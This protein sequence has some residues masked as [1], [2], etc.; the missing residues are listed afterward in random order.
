MLKSGQGKD[1]LH[2]FLKSVTIVSGLFSL[3]VCIIILLNYLQLRSANPLNSL[4][5]EELVR[6]YRE[7]PGDDTLKKEIR[8]FDLLI[9]KAF[10][11]QRWHIQTGGYL[12]IA[13]FSLFFVSFSV[14][15]MLKKKPPRPAGNPVPEKIRKSRFLSRIGIAVVSGCLLIITLVILFFSDKILVSLEDTGQTGLSAGD[16][17]TD[18]EIFSN[19][20]S[21]RGPF[22]NGIAGD[23]RYP[24]EWDGNSGKN[25][26]WKTEIPGEGFNSPVVWE[27]RIFLSGA[28]ESARE[29][30]CLDA[31]S[32]EILWQ[33]Q[34]D[35]ISSDSPGFPEVS[36]DTGYAAPGMATDG[37][38]AFALFATGMLVC[39][40]FDGNLVWDTDLGVPDNMY[41]HSSSLITYRNMLIVQYDRADKAALMAINTKIGKLLWKTN[42]DVLTS[43]AS[44]LIVQKDDHAEVVLNANPVVASYDLSSGKELWSADCMMG[45]VAPSP[46]SGCGYVFAVT[47]FATLVAI[48]PGTAEIEWEYYDDLPNV[49]SPLAVDPYVFIA[50]HYG[51]VTNLDCSSGDVLWL[52]EFDEGFYSSPIYADTHVYLLDMNGRMN[53]FKPADE[54]VPVGSPELHEETVTTPA[55]SRGRIYIRGKSHLFCIGGDNEPD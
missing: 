17:P 34:V 24:V 23:G 29:V 14:N 9:R 2:S 6:Q 12:F 10:F 51:V 48:N 27:N 16:F 5:L 35:D 7:N 4:Q 13:G 49:A 15:Q 22:G 3:L 45:E 28:D 47:Q 52:Q 20:P 53:I 41:G 30:Y 42:R 37:T 44:P 40:D 32:G 8:E 11:T 43:W 1:K 21:F 31:D 18:E 55:F 33:I 19:W 39:L 50:A 38:H 26:L 36:A 54:Y 25:I 46:A